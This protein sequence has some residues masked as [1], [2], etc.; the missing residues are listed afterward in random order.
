MRDPSLAPVRSAS[1]RLDPPG[2]QGVLL[3][4]PRPPRRDRRR[5]LPHGPERDPRRPRVVRP[6]AR[7][8]GIAGAGQR[9]P[10]KLADPSR[11][12]RPPRGAS[13]PG[14]RGRQGPL[15]QRRSGGE[16][17]GRAG[18]TRRATGRP[19]GAIH[20]RVRRE[21]GRGGAAGMTVP[22]TVLLTGATGALGPPIVAEILR[23]RG[24]V[25]ALVRPSREMPRLDIEPELGQLD[26]IS[27]DLKR[28]DG[29]LSVEDRR[30]LS[31][32]VTHVLHLAAETRFS[33]DLPE[34][35][36]GN[37]HATHVLLRLAQ[38][39][40]RLQGFGFASTLYVAG[41][42]T[43]DILEQELEETGFVNTYEQAKFETERALRARMKELPIAVY[44]MATLLGSRRTGE[45]RKP[46]AIHQAF[47]LHHRG[48]IPM[49][50]GD[51]DQR[52]ELLDTEHAAEAI[53][54][55]LLETFNPGMTYHLT[56][57]PDR[58]FTLAELIEETH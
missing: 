40:D 27:G 22:S 29:A 58:A 23:R 53:S 49:I 4:Q 44:R 51:P 45:I 12:A 24:T 5:L 19:R 26:V 34:A 25:I 10:A 21:L 31:G 46:T 15:D 18:G 28:R 32:R 36:S 56:V 52:V 3:G 43:G 33:L 30:M 55:L 48:L 16:S 13:L 20:L 11:A 39:F 35:L 7:R 1:T 6:P 2:D 9:Q 38:D 57:G 42:R 8:S 37:L 41:T 54:R 17:E 47:R 50:P 14:E